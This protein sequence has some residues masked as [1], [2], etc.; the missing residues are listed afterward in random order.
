MRDYT[1]FLLVVK[2]M[3]SV[4]RS[5]P[6]R[7]P[8]RRQP[9]SVRPDEDGGDAGCG[10]RSSDRTPS[11][12]QVTPSPVDIADWSGI[13]AATSLIPAS[14][15]LPAVSQLGEAIERLR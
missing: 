10:I 8:K 12:A 2:Y 7:T 3:S 9:N 6:R 4:A 5:P 13:P 1:R 14:V 15:T 11:P